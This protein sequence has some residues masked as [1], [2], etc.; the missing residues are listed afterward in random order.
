MEILP[1]FQMVDEERAARST[2]WRHLADLH[3][4]HL[5]HLPTLWWTSDL[6]ATSLCGLDHSLASAIFQI[7]AQVWGWILG[8]VALDSEAD[9]RATENETG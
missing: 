3:P 5:S 4:T 2:S 1:F 7:A 6:A 9:G 8:E